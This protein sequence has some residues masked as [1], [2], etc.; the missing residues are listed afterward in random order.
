MAKTC[1]PNASNRNKSPGSNGTGGP[2]KKKWYKTPPTSGDPETA[3]MTKNNRLY[4]WCSKCQSWRFHHA[5][6]H[7]AWLAC[8]KSDDGSQSNAGNVAAT[9]TFNDDDDC[10]PVGGLC[11]I[12]QE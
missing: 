12:V 1:H 11:H 2:G 6:D 7:D 4:K 8:Q 3:T 9:V 10:I 5:K